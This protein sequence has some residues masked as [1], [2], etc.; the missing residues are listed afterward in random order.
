MLNNFLLEFGYTHFFQILPIVAYCLIDFIQYF[1]EKKK[2]QPPKNKLAQNLLDTAICLAS[3][4]FLFF[5]YLIFSFMSL[6]SEL[7]D[8]VDVLNLSQSLIS[9]NH[10]NPFFVEF[11]TVPFSFYS[12]SFFFFGADALTDLLSFLLVFLGVVTV[13]S[14]DDGTSDDRSD[15]NYSLFL[16]FLFQFLLDIS[17]STLDL[18]SFFIVFE[19]LTVPMFLFFALCGSR[20]RRMRA[21]NYFFWYTILGSVPFL[22]GI[23]YIRAIIGSTSYIEL[24]SCFFTL[25]EQMTL[26]LLLAPAIF[27]KIPLCPFHLWLPEAH[28]EASTNVSIFLAG[29]LLKLG[30]YA[31]IRFLVGFLP[32]GNLYF[33][34]LTNTLALLSCIWPAFSAL[35]QADLKR[36][37]AYMSVV[38]MGVAI[39]S[40]NTYTVS[41]FYSGVYNFVSHGIISGAMFLLVGILYER[42]KT[43]HIWYYS[44][45]ATTMPLFSL[46][47]IFFIFCNIGFPGSSAFVAEFTAC[48]ALSKISIVA[49]AVV[50][51]G[52]LVLVGANLWLLR[53]LFGPPQQVYIS[54]YQDI[55][56]FSG[57]HL[58]LII[59]FSLSILVGI[60]PEFI[61]IALEDTCEYYFFKTSDALIY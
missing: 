12:S 18:L 10:W 11:D 24:S 7:I 22:M 61:F 21:F 9:H 2:A 36:I 45:L 34:D 51:L 3:N 49:L 8:Y 29:I 46:Y 43:R 41:G 27:F 33:L 31:Y 30:G 48:V 35:C 44:G 19:M 15:A 47:F 28:V 54:V 42:Y 32:L 13:L 1:I 38:H 5:L 59:F 39:L 60:F 55:S 20:E 52:S 37:I 6:F 25:H 57:D 53:I 58:S 14:S 26:W 16:F 23:I 50:L 56:F 17:L 4:D 40:I